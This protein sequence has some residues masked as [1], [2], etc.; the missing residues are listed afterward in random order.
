[1]IDW[2]SL[3]I[4]HPVHQFSHTY[5][6]PLLPQT[7]PTTAATLHHHTIAPIITS[8]TT[9]CG[10]SSSLEEAE[11]VL[12]SGGGGADGTTP[13]HHRPRTPAQPL[14]LEEG[15][16]GVP[17]LLS[18]RGGLMSYPPHEGQSCPPSPIHGGG[19]ED[20]A[21]VRSSVSQILGDFLHL[22]KWQFRL[23][24]GV[25]V[26]LF[27]SLVILIILS[28]LYGKWV[29]WVKWVK[30]GVT[31]GGA[32]PCCALFVHCCAVLCR[33]PRV[34]WATHARRRR[35][36]LCP[37][38]LCLCWAN[39]LPLP[40]SPPSQNR[41]HAQHV[42]RE[43]HLGGA[44]PPLPP[45]RRR[46]TYGHT[47]GMDGWTGAGLPACM[48][49]STNTTHNAPQNPNPVQTPFPPTPNEK[50]NDRVTCP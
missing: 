24:V 30:W 29:A 34:A 25:I 39:P 13:H 8:P 49:A 33:P 20:G 42:A 45:R 16:S 36:V 17:L 4:L 26:F 6:F 40:P 41:L 31:R 27:S 2:V 48:H 19:S 50:N 11:E 12:E 5:P 35:P 21:D 38:V 37:A 1:M 23:M 14:D 43:G 18:P 3:A 7:E 28:T 44:R 9:A 46:R 47:Y 32:S 15:S 22:P 10:S